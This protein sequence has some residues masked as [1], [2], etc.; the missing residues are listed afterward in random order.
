MCP[1]PL[2]GQRHLCSVSGRIF[3]SNPIDPA[4]RTSHTRAHAPHH[5]TA[6]HPNQPP[7][8]SQDS[9]RPTP[10]L[11]RCRL[12][13]PA[14]VSTAAAAH[15]DDQA[16]PSS[17]AYVQ[18]WLGGSTGPLAVMSP[19]RPLPRLPCTRPQSTHPAMTAGLA[20]QL[21]R[22]S[23]VQRAVGCAGLKACPLCAH[24]PGSPEEHADHF[25]ATLGRLSSVTPA[26][27]RSSRY[28]GLSYHRR[29]PSCRGKPCRTA[30]KFC[31]DH[32]EELEGMTEGFAP[33]SAVPSISRRSRSLHPT[34]L[35]HAAVAFRAADH[36]ASSGRCA[37]TTNVGT[38]KSD[39]TAPQEPRGPAR[40]YMR[41][42]TVGRARSRP[43]RNGQARWC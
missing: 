15:P 32:R 29:Q 10:H 7:R 35:S 39:R 8:P 18:S 5:P 34:P 24:D 12:R 31:S 41:P 33:S 1:V 17:A 40:R 25:R 26:A 13:P 36:R 9:R 42:A 27:G 23:P 19:S 28:R 37:D 16:V 6:T 20:L 21:A 14:A 4:L 43:G 2:L 38:A 22:H 30:E 11:A 3:A